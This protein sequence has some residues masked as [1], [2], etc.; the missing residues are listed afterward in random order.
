MR[1]LI[2]EDK[3]DA[4]VTGQQREARGGWGAGSLGQD[5]KQDYTAGVR[6]VTRKAQENSELSALITL[7]L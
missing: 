3:Q 6:N 4:L 5:S 1:G 2:P 7:P